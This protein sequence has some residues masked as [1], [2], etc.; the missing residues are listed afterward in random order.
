MSSN[1]SQNDTHSIEALFQEAYGDDIKPL[2]GKGAY[3]DSTPAKITPGMIERR[4]AAQRDEIQ[5][6]NSLD[7]PSVIEQV[8]P[9]DIL[10]F[11]RP[12]VQYAVFK[13]L[14]QGKYEIQ[15]TLDLHRKTVEQ[16]RQSVWAFLKDCQTH[17]IR[18][19]LITHGKG[20]GR[21]QPAKLKSCV[22]HWLRQVDQVLAFHTAQKQ[23]GG[24][25]ATYVLIKKN[26]QARQCTSEE[27]DRGRRRGK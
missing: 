13:K 21:E 2:S 11:L 5:C 23:H 27:L 25:G 1:K 26:A 8:D 18:C 4:K 10:S 16:S 7:A 12:G 9:Y 15:S 6:K 19:A 14:R 3:R 17:G 24:S 22:N 20:E